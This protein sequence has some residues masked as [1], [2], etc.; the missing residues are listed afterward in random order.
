MNEA[1]EMKSSK[2]ERVAIPGAVIDRFH[3]PSSVNEVV[4]VVE[5]A[6]RDK[7]GLLIAGGRTRLNWAN[8]ARKI[9]TGLSLVGLS[10]VD[11]FVPEEGVLHALAGTPIRELQA[12]AN[13]EG[14]ELALDPPGAKSTVGGTIASAAVGPRS[15]SFGRVADVIL[16]LE[17][18]L[19][20]GLLTRC[21]S[22]VV[23]N[24]TGYDMAKL[25]CGSFG[26]LGV[27]CGAWL[28]LRP[29]PAVREAYVARVEVSVSSFES[30][31]SLRG[32]TSLRALVWSEAPDPSDV[33]GSRVAQVA[34]ELGGSSEAVADDR[35][36]IVQSIGRDI[37]KVSVEH[38]DA[39]RDA[40]AEVASD[41]LVLRVRVLGSAAEEM[42]SLLVAKGL[43]VTV[44]PGLG[45]IHARGSLEQPA[46]LLSIRERAGRAG[47][48]AFF[49]KLPD[50]WL[51]D[52][53]VF[54]EQGDGASLFA[55]L[56]ERF[57]PLGILNP[58]RFAD[59]ASAH[60]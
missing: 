57:D 13:A 9:S 37:E 39:L 5:E 60:A 51:E 21:G 14:W 30:F 32:C 29:M 54:D 11:E 7:T 44:D 45:T 27:I 53:D 23:K 20:E 49:E 22:R 24:V 6:A 4:R 19:A 31:R 15:Q 2:G 18:V 36:S 43:D 42:K 50:P 40:R 58:G 1:G 41:S 59:R 16:G 25:Y 46:D 48:L 34:M 52:I 3:E 10:G 47:G 26:S 28:R 12:V 55:T 35:E 33:S 8:P 17:V 38:V 56:K